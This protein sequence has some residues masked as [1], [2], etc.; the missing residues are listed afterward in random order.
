MTGQKMCG[1]LREVTSRR[2]RGAF[3]LLEAVIA[4]F[5][6]SYAALSVLSLTQSGFVAQKRNQEIAKANLVAQSVVSDIRLWARDINNYQGNWATYN[7]TYSPTGFPEYEVTVRSLAAG[8][9]IDSPCAELESQWA[10]TTR[11]KRTMP[12]AIVPVELKITW[13]DKAEDSL[14]VLTYVGEPRRDTVGMTFDIVGPSNSSVSMN[15]E[16]D[17]SVS[18]K[19]ANGRPFPNLMFLWVPDIRYVTV[20]QDATRDGRY[21]ELLRDRVVVPPDVPPPTPPDVSPVTCYARYAGEYLD[22]N[23]PGIQLP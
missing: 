8:R 1:I 9:P 5:L 19:D 11:G 4:I 16:T 20:T 22:A 10:P 13:S 2:K 12:S 7:R 6:L 14:T 18:A 3:S 17:Y 15:Q 21:F 23:A